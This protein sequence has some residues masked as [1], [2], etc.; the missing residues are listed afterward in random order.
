MAA[1]RQTKKKGNHFYTQCD[2]CGLNQGTGAV[3]QQAIYDKAEFTPGVTFARPSNVV[4]KSKQVSEASVAPALEAKAQ[5]EP[6]PDFNPNEP[7]PVS[8]PEPKS[9]GGLSAK[10]IAGAVFVVAAGVGLWMT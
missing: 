8:E 5:S 1:V 3:R 2:C 7:E 6:E 9:S 10:L 4:E